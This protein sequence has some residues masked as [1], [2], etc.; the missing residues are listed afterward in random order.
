VFSYF[1]LGFDN[2]LSICN[3]DSSSAFFGLGLLTCSVQNHVW[4]YGSVLTYGRTPWTSD[5][6]DA[7]P[8]PTQDSMSHKDEDRHPCLESDSNPRSQC[9]GDQSPRLRPRGHRDRQQRFCF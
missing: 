6:L 8:L 3:I 7:R 9:H 4:N 5:Q 2:A 1:L